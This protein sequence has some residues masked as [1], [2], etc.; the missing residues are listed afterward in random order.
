MDINLLLTLGIILLLLVIGGILLTRRR[1]SDHLAHR[2]GPEYERT[3]ERMGGRGK[4]EA[5]LLAREKRVQKLEIVPLAPEDSMGQ[6][7]LQGECLIDSRHRVNLRCT[8]G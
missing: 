6:A 1:R 7:L 8:V 3:V 2:F 4:A 5:D